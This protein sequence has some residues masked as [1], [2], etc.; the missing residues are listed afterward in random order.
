[1]TTAWSRT[2]DE[3]E[4]RLDAATVTLEHPRPSSG[5]PL[6]VKPEVA[7]FVAG[8]PAEPFPAELVDRA[9]ALVKRSVDLEQ[10]LTNERD[11]VSAELRRLPRARVKS[12]HSE[13]HFELKA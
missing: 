2:L 8:G 3:C 6:E 4:A 1:M 9:L 11:R 13:S 12:T 10:R 5:Q 7:P